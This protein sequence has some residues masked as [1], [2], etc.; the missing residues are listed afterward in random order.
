MRAFGAL[1]LLVLVASTSACGDDESGSAIGSGGANLGGTG[2]ASGGGGASTG[3]TAGG[4]GGAGTGGAGGGAAGTGGGTATPSCS[5]ALITVPAP[6]VGTDFHPA[7][8]S[9]IDAAS[10]G[11]CLALPSGEFRLDGKLTSSK[12]ISLL[13]GQGG[14]ERTTLYRAEDVPDAQL[15]SWG[16]MFV[17]EINSTAPCDVFV[18]RL[19]LRGRTPSRTPGD[20]G[21]LA[22]DTGLAF[23]RCNGFVVSDSKFE[24]F[25]EAGLS[26]RHDDDLAKGLIYDSEFVRN[27]KG[28]KGLGLGYGVVVYGTNEGWV[29]SPEFGTGSFIFIEDNTFFE[30][31]H[32][33]AAGGAAKYVFRHNAVTDNLWGHA[34]DAHEGR[35]PNNGD[36]TYSTRA[37]EAYSN[38]IINEHFVD[39]APQVPGE[40]A[41]RLPLRGIG[42]RGGEAVIYD[43]KIRGTLWG[44][45]LISYLYD[46][47]DQ[48]PIPYQIGYASGLALGESH[49]GTGPSEADGDV[50][51]WNNDW[52]PYAPQYADR[53]LQVTGP[54]LKEGRDYH[55]DTVRP[56]YAPFPYPHPDRH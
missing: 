37:V 26:V 8:Q 52:L 11:D 21:S 32:S 53:A 10:D 14:S 4:S 3:G 7:L 15:E 47:P 22:A 48:Y 38:T 54:H 51:L 2:G 18:H 40:D 1:T 19:H 35:G 50:F 56:G 28:E 33:V 45:L 13:G 5:G 9:A 25:G 12:R 24:N 43:N 36:N 17:Y 27:S 39:G 23:R 30:H 55:V 44:S 29:P 31:R 42:I 46:Y 20:G 41:N 6:V 16:K 34:I 49:S